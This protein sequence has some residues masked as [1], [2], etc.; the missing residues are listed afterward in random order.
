MVTSLANQMIVFLGHL[1]CNCY[2]YHL[3]E[4]KWFYLDLSKYLDFHT[5]PY[6]SHNYIWEPQDGPH[7]LWGVISHQCSC[8][9]HKNSMECM[10][11]ILSHVS[12]ATV[13]APRHQYLLHMHIL[14]IHCSNPLWDVFIVI[15]YF[16]STSS[17]FVVHTND[18]PFLE[19]YLE[20]S[21][22]SS[23]VR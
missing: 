22:Y 12:F 13:V 18:K 1:G 14:E 7:V 21:H 9:K 23:V 4:L 16:P 3:L 19:F 2:L 5:R 17:N 11:P 8:I 20:I 10:D 15:C 6:L